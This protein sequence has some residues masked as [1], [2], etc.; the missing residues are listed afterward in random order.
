MESWDKTIDF[1]NHKINDEKILKKYLKNQ[2]KQKEKLYKVISVNKL[3]DKDRIYIY[4][5]IVYNWT[6]SILKSLKKVIKKD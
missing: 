4:E 3:E 5:E 1:I 6:N 2:S